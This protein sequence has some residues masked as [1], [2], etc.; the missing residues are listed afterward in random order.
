MSVLIYI[1]LMCAVGWFWLVHFMVTWQND[2]MMLFLIGLIMPPIGWIHG[3][4]VTFGL[5]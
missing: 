4:L 3:F 2:L 1:V 5:M